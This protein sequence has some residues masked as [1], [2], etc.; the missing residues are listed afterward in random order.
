MALKDAILETMAECEPY[1]AGDL[2]NELDE[3]RRT[4][5]YNLRQ[6]AESGDVERKK[7]SE[8]RV[9]WWVAE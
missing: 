2:A 1:T 9:S 5:D 7:H 8:R 3:P 6:L 4:V